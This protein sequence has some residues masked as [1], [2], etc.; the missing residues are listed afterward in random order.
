MIGMKTR[1]SWRKREKF[2]KRL[3]AYTDEGVRQGTVAVP[4]PADEAETNIIEVTIP[5]LAGGDVVGQVIDLDDKPVAGLKVKASLSRGGG[6]TW[7]TETRDDGWFKMV[8]LP[9]GAKP[10]WDLDSKR[11]KTVK[12]DGR[13]DLDLSLLK[14]GQTLEVDPIV[15]I[16]YKELADPLPELEIGGLSNEAAFKLLAAYIEDCKSLVPKEHWVG[17]AW[18]QP[19][20]LRRFFSSRSSGDPIPSFRKRMVKK[21][22]PVIKKMADRDPG[23]EFEL[24]LL[25]Y[26]DGSIAQ[27]QPLGVR[28]LEQF[29]FK[30]LMDRHLK[31]EKAQ[32]PIVR[33]A[34]RASALKNR[35]KT[36]EAIRDGSPF[37][38]TKTVASIRIVMQ[39]LNSC[40][41]AVGDKTGDKEFKEEAESLESS[42]DQLKKI[43]PEILAKSKNELRLMARNRS[44]FGMML[45]PEVWISSHMG[46]IDKSRVE[47]ILKVLDG[48]LKD[49]GLEP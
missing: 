7:K 10:D 16:D 17:Y 19:E 3:Q 15:C 29:C 39:R 9:E 49:L 21:I 13:I 23:S 38:E 18:D 48:G 43:D 34:N 45:R 32:K 24:K 42:L 27:N 26:V 40:R 6:Q 46:Q 1:L 37:D 25:M 33:L 5:L 44:T 41:N 11:V 31:N 12:S 36:W 4:L 30:R 8:G 22:L 14:A 20:K 2:W 28:E 47:E 35:S